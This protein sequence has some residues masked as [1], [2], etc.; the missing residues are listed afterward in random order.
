VAEQNVNMLAS[1]LTLILAAA[2]LAT[3]AKKGV[4]NVVPVYEFTLLVQ[5]LA[6]LMPPLLL[7]VA[8][9]IICKG[10]KI[11]MAIAY[12]ENTS[13]LPVATAVQ[14]ASPSPTL[15]SGLPFTNTVGLPL[16][17]EATCGLHGVPG[18]K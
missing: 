16:E 4:S 12:P 18:R 2:E 9:A 7:S 17:I 3:A 11:P 14:P 5:V 13:E 6:S 1:V 10:V 15:A 8:P